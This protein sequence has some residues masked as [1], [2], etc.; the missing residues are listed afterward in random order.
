MSEVHWLNGS[1]FEVM[2]LYNRFVPVGDQPDDLGGF[3]NKVDSS[4]T[5]VA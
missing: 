2:L 1:L 3:K 5:A 4:K